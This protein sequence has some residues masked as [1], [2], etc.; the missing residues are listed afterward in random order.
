MTRMPDA[1]HLALCACLTGHGQVVE[2]ASC[3]RVV[4]NDVTRAMDTPP[5]GLETQQTA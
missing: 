1:L 4:M 2:P 5:F 3:D